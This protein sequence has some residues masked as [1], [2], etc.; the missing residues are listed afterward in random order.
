MSTDHPSPIPE[1]GWR[2]AAGVPPSARPG[3][4]RI[5]ELAGE[6]EPA[7][8]AAPDDDAAWA[9]I[10]SRLAPDAPAPADRPPRPSSRQRARRLRWPAAVLVLMLVAGVIFWR[11]PF[12][13]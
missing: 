8:V 4:E 11:Q 12:F 5:W 9:D 10:T 1:D 6:T 2:E 3:I 7:P 13:C